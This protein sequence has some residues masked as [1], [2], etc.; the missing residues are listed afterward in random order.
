MQAP[1]TTRITLT[2]AGSDSS[3]GAGIQADLKTFTVLGVYGASAI[4]GITAQNT[5]GVQRIHN[6]P[7]GLVAAQIDSIMTD[8]GCH[9]AKTGMLGNA[10]I[11]EAVADRIAHYRIP[12]LVVDPVMIAKSGHALLEADAVR[13][14][15]SA[16]LPLATVVTPNLPEAEALLGREIFGVG[17]LEVA[18]R[19][20]TDLGPAA[21]IVKGGH[22]MG[23]PIDV[24]YIRETDVALHLRAPRI[25][26]RHVHGTGCTF[27][28][29]LAAGLARGATLAQAFTQ[30]KE[31]I[32][33]AIRRAP[34]IGG[35]KGPVGHVE[36]GRE[37]G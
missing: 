32:T 20:L 27:S 31:Y 23:E 3:G 15:V 11:V 37:R 35:G 4:T 21:A 10:E 26:Q 8:I 34:G 5:L 17:H 12:N 29:A 13:L 33:R 6:L 25:Q 19:A 24:L 2:I 22:L 28:A 7:P 30:A 18:A 1:S 14:M 16:L 9:A 36:A